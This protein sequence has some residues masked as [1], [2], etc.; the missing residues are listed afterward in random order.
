MD[1]K[2]I[3]IILG[4]LVILGLIFT[5]INNSLNEKNNPC[6]LKMEGLG[7]C[8]VNYFGFE[9]DS[10]NN[11]CVEKNI[12]GCD[13]QIPFHEKDVCENSCVN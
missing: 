8:K 10:L 5:V 7:T 13:A 6:N 2:N 11:E 12:N 1:G 3:I 9:Y 4:F